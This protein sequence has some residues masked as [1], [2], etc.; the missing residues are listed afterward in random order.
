[1]TIYTLSYFRFSSYATVDIRFGQLTELR[2]FQV[3]LDT[4][5]PFI[6]GHSYI[7][8]GLRAAEEEFDSNADQNLPKVRLFCKTKLNNFSKQ[9]TLPQMKYCISS[10]YFP[11]RSSRLFR[12]VLIIIIMII[13]IITIIIIIIIIIIIFFFKT[14][15]Y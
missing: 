8:K 12:L 6:G 1:M 7:E 11:W 9:L 14:K 4:V 10:H 13:I 2:H 5:M 3:E 15:L